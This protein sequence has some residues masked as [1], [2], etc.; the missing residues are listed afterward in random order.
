MHL[1][2]NRALSLGVY[3]LATG[4]VSRARGAEAAGIFAF[5]QAFVLMF[6]WF[7]E[8]FS[9]WIGPFPLPGGHSSKVID[10]ETPAWLI[11]AFGWLILIG[12]FVVTYFFA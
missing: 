3:V 7:A 8:Y 11:A 5:T 1:S 4:L 2:W 10:Q 12:V 6:I 9:G